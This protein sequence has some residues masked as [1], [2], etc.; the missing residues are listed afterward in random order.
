MSRPRVVLISDVHYSLNTLTLADAAMRQAI[1]KANELNVPLIVAGDLHDSKAM[2]RGECV[3]AM[4]ETFKAIKGK[5]YVLVGN[6]DRLNEKKAAHSLEFLRPYAEIIDQDSCGE[7][8]YPELWLLPYYNDLDLLKSTLNSIPKG[9]TII[10]HQGV[11]KAWGGH[12]VHDKTA[13]PAEWFEDFRVI[14]GHYHRAQ[15]IKCGRPRKGA[16]GL[17]SY[18]GTPY[19]ITFAEA[20]DGPKGFRI[21]MDDGLLEFVPTNLRKHCVFERTVEEIGNMSRR[22]PDGAFFKSMGGIGAPDEGDL[23]WLKVSGI[24]SEL[25]EIDK[26]ALGVSLGIGANYKLDL[27]PTDSHTETQ[28]ADEPKMTDLEVLDKLIDGLPDDAEYKGYL[29]DLVAGVLE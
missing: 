24:R 25:D 1:N 26:Q 6:H 8:Y 20:G 3:N 2:M 4:I 7:Y 14:S 9:A 23:V 13:A 27:I 11:N 19:T 29:K 10:M 17:F 12:Y 16:V 28:K 15:D 21:L 18:V 5:C 22:G